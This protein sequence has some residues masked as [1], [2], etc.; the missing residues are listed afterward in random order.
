MR[1]E[2]VSDLLNKKAMIVILY[3][4]CIMVMH[5][6][7]QHSAANSHAVPQQYKLIK[8]I[9]P[10]HQV[11]AWHSLPQQCTLRGYAAPQRQAIER[12]ALSQRLMVAM[13]AAPQRS[14][15]KRHAAPQHQVMTLHSSTQQCT[16]RGYAMPQR[17]AIKRHAFRQHLMMVMIAAPQRSAGNGHAVP[18]RQ[19]SASRIKHKR[20]V[21]KLPYVPAQSYMVY[22][23]NHSTRASRLRNWLRFGQTS[24]HHGNIKIIQANCH[25]SAESNLTL[26]EAARSSHADIVLASEVHTTNNGRTT[27]FNNSINCTSRPI[28]INNGSRLQTAAAIIIL[29]RSIPFICV[30]GEGQNAHPSFT[31]GIIGTPRPYLIISVYIVPRNNG[32]ISEQNGIQTEYLDGIYNDIKN[33]INEHRD[34][35]IVLGG[36]FNTRHPSW[37]SFVTRVDTTRCYK[38]INFAE[39]CGLYNLN[40][41]NYEKGLATYKAYT[42]GDSNATGSSHIDLTF[43]DKN[44]LSSIE[45]WQVKPGIMVSDHACIILC[46]DEN[47]QKHT[48]LR[49][50]FERLGAEE[51]RSIGNLIDT[52]YLEHMIP[53]GLNTHAEIDNAIQTLTSHIHKSIDK[54]QITKNKRP[55]QAKATNCR[56]N[57]DTRNRNFSIEGSI[58]KSNNNR[59]KRYR[60]NCATTEPGK[61]YQITGVTDELW[62]LEN[63]TTPR[64]PVNIYITLEIITSKRGYQRWKRRAK[65]ILAGRASQN[66]KK[67]EAPWWNQNLNKLRALYKTASKTFYSGEHVLN[68]AVRKNLV[69]ARNL[70]IKEIRKAKR[71][72]WMSF[73]SLSSSI[74][75]WGEAYKIIMNKRKFKSCMQSLRLPN[76][77]NITDQQEVLQTF[78]DN[79]FPDDDESKDNELH[80]EI[81]KS[82]LD[83]H[84]SKFDDIT[85]TQNEVKSL[86]DSLPYKK[87]PG[88]D[89]ITGEILRG[90]SYKVCKYITSIIQSCLSTGYFPT[91]WKEAYV[92][93]IPKPGKDPSTL[94]GWRPICLLNNMAKILDKIV[95]N[96]IM[97][98]FRQT[99]GMSQEQFGFEAHKSTV[100]AVKEIVDTVT[101]KRK[102]GVVAIVCLDVSGAFD[103]A[104]HPE[105]VAQLRKASISHN[106]LDLIK[107][108]LHNRKATLEYNGSKVS[109][110]PNRGCPQ[111][112]SSGPMLW[113]IV[114]ND[115]LSIA[116][117][118]S[119]TR[120]IAYADDATLIVWART[121]A[122]LQKKIARSIKQVMKYGDRVKL[123]FGPDK[124]ELLYFDA[125]RGTDTHNRTNIPVTGATLQP[126]LRRPRIKKR[127]KTNPFT[128]KVENYTITESKIV[129]ILGIYLN[130]TLT[131]TDH[132]NIAI[133]KANKRWQLLAPSCSNKWGLDPK[134]AIGIFR[135]AIEPVLT[136]GSPIW[137]EE[138]H[139][140]R[141]MCAKLIKW[142]QDKLLRLSRAYTK[143]SKSIVNVVTGII[144]I[145]LL[146]EG[147]AIQWKVTNIHGY[148]HKYKQE[149]VNNIDIIRTCRI[150]VGI[151]DIPISD[152]PIINVSPAR[153][154]TRNSEN[155]YDTNLNDDK[156]IEHHYIK[157]REDNDHLLVYHLNME[158]GGVIKSYRFKKNPK[159]S[160]NT[161]VAQLLATEQIIDEAKKRRLLL[162][163]KICYHLYFENT[164]NTALSAKLAMD[165]DNEEISNV[166]RL[167]WPNRKYIKMY[168]TTENYGHM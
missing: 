8:L 81:R 129:R 22:V 125:I 82:M 158:T 21:S 111:G 112:S 36:D 23:T 69:T 48:S 70:Y 151:P 149:M 41:I 88:I 55:P 94:K 142:Q 160:S 154:A 61:A 39:E 89:G 119:D 6:M 126:K 84:T 128:I 164:S 99:I 2:T 109:K 105:I 92:V 161:T 166:L 115:L 59:A 17:Q 45:R 116:K 47:I 75:T 134:S 150:K 156:L 29:N 14:A 37:D 86:I 155:G 120:I 57:T 113:N 1:K 130:N 19:L 101:E 147:Q 96:N 140:S 137:H 163:E 83:E 31:A 97:V 56:L 49:K 106:L 33:L 100:H 68:E 95:I 122:L 63:P 98:Q 152:G 74:D 46:I 143:I 118:N 40:A 110:C 104:W 153:M 51:I 77:T 26:L 20:A 85:V 66:K 12:H 15:A 73:V 52:Q 54:Y 35:R 121:Q 148:Q 30:T 60:F 168:E 102:H 79:F 124:T 132:I 27:G 16:T 108:Y 58:V 123:S 162:K 53:L 65:E 139:C 87:S 144:P 133:D 7:A 4:Q 42:H 10:Q 67:N 145:N 13:P 146:I 76:G 157:A 167:Y 32:T 131:W 93:M 64:E 72:S 44:T 159:W 135:G 78:M 90:I 3:Q 114:Y 43:V 107:S 80:K 165:L 103:N 24:Y 136:Y 34:K 18:Q 9:T 28:A 62:E 11:M 71:E 91:K 25:K 38:L 5:T 117:K 138:V 141:K 127:G 50:S